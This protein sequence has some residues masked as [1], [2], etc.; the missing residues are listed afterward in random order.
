MERLVGLVFCTT[1]QVMKLDFN[2]ECVFMHMQCHMRVY[3]VP[4]KKILCFCEILCL[5]KMLKVGVPAKVDL[6]RASAAIVLKFNGRR[7]CLVFQP[8]I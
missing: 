8:G 7:L 3:M 6:H 2:R 1:G 4:L 5:C